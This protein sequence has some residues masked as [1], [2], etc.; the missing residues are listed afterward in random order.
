M[1]ICS[2]SRLPAVLA[3]LLC[4]AV[5]MGL[6]ASPASASEVGP[7]Q[8]SLERTPVALFAGWVDKAYSSLE[9]ALRDSQKRVVQF[10]LVGMLIAMW[11]IWW[12][13]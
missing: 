12:R 10:C 4:A 6:L 3:T 7:I 9:S 13:K 2:A 11:I 8:V 1:M 5:L